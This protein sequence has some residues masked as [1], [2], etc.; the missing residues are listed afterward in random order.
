MDF[1]DTN[2]ILRYL[3]RDHPEKAERCYQLL[4][5]AKRRETDLVTTESVIAEVV[6]VLASKSHYRQS[7]QDIHGLL[8]PIIRLP[9]LKVPHRATMLRAL[10]L[11]AG[12]NLDFTDALSVAHMERLKVKTILSY[13][14]DFDRISG[15]E[16]QE[17]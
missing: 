5:R 8:L 17:P 12:T 16:R 9:G 11:Y 4:Q 2:I 3:T 15:V 13:D 10:D 14:Q 7:R 6:F 1:L